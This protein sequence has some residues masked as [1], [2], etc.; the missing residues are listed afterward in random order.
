MSKLKWN[1]S[2]SENVWIT[3]VKD[4]DLICYNII[5]DKWILICENLF[6]NTQ[7]FNAKTFLEAEK[8]VNKLIEDRLNA[9]LEFKEYF[10][11]SAKDISKELK[12]IMA[13]AY[14][15]Q[16][17]DFPHSFEIDALKNAY[18][19][20]KDNPLNPNS[21]EKILKEQEQK[22]SF[23]KKVYEDFKSRTEC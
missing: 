12:I 23:N 11:C 20:F 8:I 18:E 17:C 16:D 22:S 4:F 19:Y 15:N 13:F 6:N 1:K 9:L 14:T 2:D 7:E 5:N 10:P 21:P 3:K